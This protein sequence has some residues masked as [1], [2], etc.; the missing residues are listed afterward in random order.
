MTSPI[1]KGL[2]A[3]VIFIVVAIFLMLIG[4]TPLQHP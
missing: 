3:A 4:L 1:R 2:R